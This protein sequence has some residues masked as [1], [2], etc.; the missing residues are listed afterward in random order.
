MGKFLEKKGKRILTK[1]NFM[2]YHSREREKVQIYLN[3]FNTCFI[4]TY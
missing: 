2:S 3:E 4:T 1:L